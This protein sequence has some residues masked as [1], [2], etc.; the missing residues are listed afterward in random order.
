MSAQRLDFCTW[1]RRTFLT[2]HVMLQHCNILNSSGCQI[3]CPIHRGA[4][5]GMPHSE[6][7]GSRNRIGCAAPW[8]ISEWRSMMSCFFPFMA[9]AYSWVPSSPANKLNLKKWDTFKISDPRNFCWSNAYLPRSLVSRGKSECEVYASGTFIFAIATKS[10]RNVCG[11]FRWCFTYIPQPCNLF[12]ELHSDSPD[13][14]TASSPVGFH[15]IQ[16]V[17]ESS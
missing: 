2:M 17:R 9:R 6:R 15:P 7:N 11:L 12:P 4:A 3:V 16:T 14:P 8:N 5:V 13:S 1:T 10:L